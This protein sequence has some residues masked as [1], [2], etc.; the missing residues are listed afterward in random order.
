[1]NFNFFAYGRSRA[2]AH[3]SA[4]RQSLNTAAAALLQRCWRST[5]ITVNPIP[6]KVRTFPPS[7]RQSNQ[8]EAQYNRLNRRQGVTHISILVGTLIGIVHS[9]APHPNHPDWPPTQTN[10]N[11]KILPHLNPS[12]RPFKTVGACQNVLISQKCPHFGNDPAEQTS[13]IL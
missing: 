1:M 3:P 4:I 5:C 11:L 9:P 6:S 10:S 12:N 13:K 7:G 2:E 8:R